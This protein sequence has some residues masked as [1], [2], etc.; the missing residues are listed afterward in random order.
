MTRNH[1]RGIIGRGIIEKESLRRNRERGIKVGQS[2]RKRHGAS[3]EHLGALWEASGMDL[4]IQES[5]GMNLK[6]IWDS[7]RGLQAEKASQ[8]HLEIRSQKLQYI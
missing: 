4:V 6:C 1:G 5:V 2:L 3:G 7:F 8:R